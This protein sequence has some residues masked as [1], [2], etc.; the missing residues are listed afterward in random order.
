[1]LDLKFKGPWEKVR[2]ELEE[3]DAEL[4]GHDVTLTVSE[5]DNLPEQNSGET[6]ADFLGDYIGCIEGTTESMSGNLGEKFTEYLT[7]KHKQGSL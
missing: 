6:L 5:S 2:R 3:Y 7:E 4:G 1:M